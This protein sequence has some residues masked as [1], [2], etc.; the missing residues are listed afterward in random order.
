[1]AQKSCHKTHD[2]LSEPPKVPMFTGV[3]SKHS[4][5]DSLSDAFAS[6][7]TAIAKALSPSPLPHY[8]KMAYSAK[9]SFSRKSR[10]SFHHLTILFDSEDINVTIT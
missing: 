8:V 1:M 10:L 7:A 9:K 5:R 3:V 6:A 4:Q 2:D